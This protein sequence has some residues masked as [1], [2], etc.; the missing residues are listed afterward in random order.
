MRL[1]ATRGLL[2]LAAVASAPLLLTIRSTHETVPDDNPRQAMINLCHTYL[3]WEVVSHERVEGLSARCG[4]VMNQ[5]A[6]H[7]LH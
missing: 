6:I 1:A 7:A 4:Y 3:K 5:E 2:L